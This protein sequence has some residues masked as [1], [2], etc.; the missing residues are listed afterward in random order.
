M[1]NG[2]QHA[3]D[4]GGPLLFARRPDGPCDAPLRCVRIELGGPGNL[5]PAQR[6]SQGQ[7]GT[8]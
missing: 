2:T 8:H 7:E 3:P 6:G 1:V 5:R 4:R